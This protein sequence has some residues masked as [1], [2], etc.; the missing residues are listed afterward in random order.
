MRHGGQ[1]HAD[2]DGPT[3]SEAT[4]DGLVERRAIRR[5]RLAAGALAG[6]M[7]SVSPGIWAAPAAAVAFVV[8]DR[9]AYA[10]GPGPAPEVKRRA[11]DAAAMLAED[12]FEEAEA[13]IEANLATDPDPFVYLQ[14]VL[15]ER[16]GDCPAAVRAYRRYIDLGV[17]DQDAAAAQAGIDRCVEARGN[18]TTV[19]GNPDAGASGTAGGQPDSNATPD[20][21]RVDDRV[22]PVDGRW[23]T[24]PAGA[25]F[26][27]GGVAVVAAGG[28]VWSQAGRERGAAD[29]A[30]SLS[31]YERHGARARRMS[32]AGVTMVSIGAALLIAGAVRYGIVASRKRPSTTARRSLRLRPSAA[33]LSVAF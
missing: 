28:V 26:T 17:P 1:Q 27:I 19:P 2:V 15:S 13:L 16:R 33:G 6:C 3:V 23:W 20:A 9:R 29:D 7:A 11:Q 30:G 18:D 21:G 24:D 32:V 8:G 10:A 22:E 14:G 4:S 31:T 12:R 5:R 25:T